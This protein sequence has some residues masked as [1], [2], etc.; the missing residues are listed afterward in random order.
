MYAS[1]T[2]A[3]RGRPNEVMSESTK[4][5]EELPPSHY[6]RECRKF[7]MLSSFLTTQSTP[8]SLPKEFRMKFTLCLCIALAVW[9]MVDAMPQQRFNNNNNNR[10]PNYRH[11]EPIYSYGLDTSNGQYAKFNG[12]VKGIPAG[13]GG[14]RFGK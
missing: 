6:K 4:K 14:G 5:S 3:H 9:C 7:C 11:V 13:H 12:P 2:S 1:N 8:Q 10:G